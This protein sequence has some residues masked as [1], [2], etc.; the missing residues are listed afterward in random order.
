[1]TIEFTQELQDKICDLLAIKPM[2]R[3][4]QMEGMPS[5]STVQKWYAVY[6]QFHE[7]CRQARDLCADSEVE[8][9]NMLIDDVI[10]GEVEP[11]RARVALQALQWRIGMLDKT[12]YGE[13]PNKLSITNTT[14]N[15]RVDINLETLRIA[16]PDILASAKMQVKQAIQ[17]A[18]KQLVETVIDE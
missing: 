1:M 10:S 5:T 14:D 18:D 11:D 12:R 3:I 4:C 13:K 6:P 9:H 7:A 8:R 17:T 2:Y 16:P 15:R